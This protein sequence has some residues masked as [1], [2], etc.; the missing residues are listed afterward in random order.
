MPLWF[1]LLVIITTTAYAQGQQALVRG[2]QAQGYRVIDSTSGS[3]A[4]LWYRDGYY[5]Y[6]ELDSDS[7]LLE[8]G[9]LDCSNKTWVTTDIWDSRLRV[10]YPVDAVVE[11]IQAESAADIFYQHACK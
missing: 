1:K 11:P 5:R 2:F 6:A 9:Q 8:S 4:M 10:H 3:V 7:Y